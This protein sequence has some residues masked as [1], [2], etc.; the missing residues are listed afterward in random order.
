[1]SDLDAARILDRG[2]RPY[3]GP[4]AGRLAAARSVALYSAR[5]ALGLRRPLSAKVLPT[6]SVF[7][8]YVP[9]IVFVGITALFEEVLITEPD[10]LPSY[11]DYYGYIT[12]AIVVFTAFVAPELLC[13]DRR[14]R[15]LG[16]YLASPLTRDSYLASKA[17]AV[18]AVLGLVTVGPLLFLLLARTIAGTG[19]D[20]PAQVLELLW[21][22]IV[23]G[24]VIA[25]LQAALSLAMASTTTRRA[26]A[27]AAIILILVGSSAVSG[28]LLDTGDAPEGV[29]LLNLFVL[30]FELVRRIY[31][32]VPP[33]DEVTTLSTG[34]LLA[35]YLGW[36]LLFAAFA[37]VR[38]RRIEVTR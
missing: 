1:V 38:Y 2:Y 15:M 28:T 27:S 18:L 11:S 29:F 6:I 33:G 30:P 10:L 35:G 8:A 26:A 23:A 20:G 32:D 31:G 9:A 12:A 17:V 21:K 36:T 19:P 34:A 5:R 25:S 13:S 37:W 22:V 14:D 3:E 16:L 24:L 7:I 4:R